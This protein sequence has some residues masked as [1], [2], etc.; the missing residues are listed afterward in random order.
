MSRRRRRRSTAELGLQ[1][2]SDF[3]KSATRNITV[4]VWMVRIMALAFLYLL[5]VTVNSILIPEV[6][7]LSDVGL[8]LQVIFLYFFVIV[9]ALLTLVGYIA[10]PLARAGT[11][12]AIHYFWAA[13]AFI[14]NNLFSSPGLV[15]G[16][17]EDALLGGN[18]DP[19]APLAYLINKPQRLLYEDIALHGFIMI[20]FILMIITGIA[21]VR[22]SSVQMSGITLVLTQVI[23]AWA[24]MKD[25]TLELTLDTTSYTSLLGS[26]LFQLALI[27]Y[28]YFEFSL[29]TGYIYSLT[30]P[31]LTRQK[32]VGSQLSRLSEFRLGMTKLGTEEEKASRKAV[33]ERKEDEEIEEEEK[34]SSA[35]AAGSGS[36]AHK[37][38]GADALIFLLDSAQDSLFAKPGGEKERLTGRLQRYHDGLLTHDPDL[39]DKLGGSAEKAFKPFMVLITVL[40]SM[41][42]RTVLLIGFAW[43]TLNS[44]TILA[45]IALPPAITNSIELTQPEGTLI[46][47]IPLIFFIIGISYLMARI[48]R[49]VVKA[50]EL[51]IR[52]SDIQKLLKAG[53]AISSRKDAE[54]MKEEKISSELKSA[55]EKPVARRRRRKTSQRKK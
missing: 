38:F 39:D 15:P 48:Q 25:A 30:T 55:K 7:V 2:A 8:L 44:S 5:L 29:Q 49:A 40:F 52:E 19:L 24:Y 23:I 1:T 32:R 20:L 34:T 41:T 31:T 37:K 26:T 10:T 6:K 4:V 21:F 12:D 36:T 47:L 13:R 35:L 17:S 9:L 43:M 3:F 18:T 16:M 27:S 51:I 42:I 54:K 46:I 22:K 14:I 50:E 45:S 28:L 11:D 33:K 53:K